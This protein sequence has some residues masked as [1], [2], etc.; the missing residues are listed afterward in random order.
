M[1]EPT[2]LSDEHLI[3]AYSQVVPMRPRA[4]QRRPGHEQRSAVARP[5]RASRRQGR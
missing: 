3:D 5:A 4:L 2:R 1:F